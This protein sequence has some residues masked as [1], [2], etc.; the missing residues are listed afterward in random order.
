MA[1]L[2]QITPTVQCQH[3]DERTF[4][5]KSASPKGRNAHGCVGVWPAGPLRLHFDAA[6]GIRF[7]HRCQSGPIV[8]CGDLSLDW[9]KAISPGQRDHFGLGLGTAHPNVVPPESP[10]LS[11]FVPRYARWVVARNDLPTAPSWDQI[12]RTTLPFPDQSLVSCSICGRYI[13][14]KPRQD[15]R[16]RLAGGHPHG[17]PTVDGYVLPRTPLQP[18]IPRQAPCNIRIGRSLDP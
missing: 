10:V 16:G 3:G 14:D 2:E 18:R 7:I 8:V 15:S 12:R 4:N 11:E 17:T 9:L 5:R 13:A 6:D 1:I